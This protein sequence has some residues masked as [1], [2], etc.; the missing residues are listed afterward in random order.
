MAETFE[1]DELPQ[2]LASQSSY[3][4][5]PL[6][7]KKF[8]NQR[9]RHEGDNMLCGNSRVIQE[10]REKKD[11]EKKE[12]KKTKGRVNKD[13]SIRHTS[14]LASKAR[15]TKS[16]YKQQMKEQLTLEETKNQPIKENKNKQT[17]KEKQVDDTK[18]RKL[19]EYFKAPPAKPSVTAKKN[20]TFESPA[21][22]KALDVV[23]PSSVTPPSKA[24]F[25]KYKIPKKDKVKETPTTHKGDS[26]KQ[27]APP[28]KVKQSHK[29]D[30]IKQ[31]PLPKDKQ[32]PPPSKV[33][34]SHKG[35]TI[36]QTPL[37]KI[38]QRPPP[39]PKVVE[40]DKSVWRQGKASTSTPKLKHDIIE[41]V[42]ESPGTSSSS[43]DSTP[44]QEALIKNVCEKAEFDPI[45]LKNIKKEA[46]E[47]QQADEQRLKYDAVILDR[48]RKR[49]T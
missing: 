8:V 2:K 25:S 21:F 17:N 11:Q 42:S 23:I 45:K 15:A 47:D 18:Q 35:D 46:I 40:T 30:T 41:V 16:K 26:I 49:K 33:K 29:G 31:T 32:T 24:N 12:N 6:K 5:Y 44:K 39:P 43:L 14:D 37:P 19:N 38:K 1:D 48:F 13:N 34:Q 27:T 20:V 7:S 36:K 3:I 4:A 28:P 10:A 22:D 9:A